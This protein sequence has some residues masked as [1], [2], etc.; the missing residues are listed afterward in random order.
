MFD[1]LIV[2]CGLSGCVLAERLAGIGKRV[3]ILDRRS[4]IGGNCYDYYDNAGILVHKY[5]PH[6][7]RTN[8]KSV[9]DYLSRFTDWRYLYYRVKV[10][11]DG[12]LVTLPINLDTVNDLYGFG[13]NSDQL[14]RWFAEQASV[15]R[16]VKNSEDAIISKVGREL[17][18]KVYRSYTVKQ[19]GLEP[20][21]LDASVCERIPVRTNRDD[22]YFTERYQ[23][24]PSHGYHSM[25]QRMLASPNITVML[26]AEFAEVRALAPDAKVLY[27][28]SIDE[29]FGYNHG[30]L[31]YRS[32]RF[33]H[34]T[35]PME[36][37]QPVSQ[38]NY[39]ADY[40][41]TRIVEIKHVTGQI[42]PHTTIVREYPCGEG[43]PF[44]PIPNAAHEAQY[45]KYAQDAERE[46][47]CRFIGRLA[48]YKYLNMDQVVDNALALFDEIAKSEG[49]APR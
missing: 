44:Y 39:P 47:G 18:E 22:R 3:L 30:R 35:L 16:E 34:E 8:K 19:W 43:D 5:G 12:R 11:V 1:Y 48:Q 24:M 40:D 27:T 6:Y 41:F 29:Y 2:G 46:G 20:S 4:H 25:F 21:E 9:F 45:R 33:E 17:Y 15:V 36:F 10:M 13:F 38:I 23:A 28:G 49:A 42:H 26:Q 37:Y 7:F 14:A 31:P 32:L